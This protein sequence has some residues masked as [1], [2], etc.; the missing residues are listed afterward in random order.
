MAYMPDIKSL[1]IR[2]I[3]QNLDVGRHTIHVNPKPWKK[4]LNDANLYHPILK[5][6]AF[7]SISRSHLLRMQNKKTKDKCLEILMWGYSSGGRGHN[8]ENALKSLDRIADAASLAMPNWIDYYNTLN[9]IE[10]IG[11]STITKFAYFYGHTFNGYKSV[12]LDEQI[13]KIL[14]AEAWANAPSS[15]GNRNEWQTN[16]ISYLKEINKLSDSFCVKVDQIELFLYLLG[17]HFK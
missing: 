11:I 3:I 14:N 9:Q 2:Q 7:Y 6:S 1:N 17:P 10:G 16:Y 4:I 12:I 5:S 8:I 13:A 15:V